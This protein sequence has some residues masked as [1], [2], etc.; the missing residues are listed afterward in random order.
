MCEG[1]N[2]EK[3]KKCRTW[4]ETQVSLGTVKAGLGGHEAGVF[5]VD[6]GV[7]KAPIP[8]L[9]K[10]SNGDVCLCDLQ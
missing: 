9:K 5:G 3:G 10:G 7:E 1:T 4:P 8:F 6:E 2:V